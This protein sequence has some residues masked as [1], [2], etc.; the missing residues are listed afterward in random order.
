MDPRDVEKNNRIVREKDKQR[1]A[2]WAQE[3]KALAQDKKLRALPPA[4]EQV[5]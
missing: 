4:G 5:Q 3:K 1:Y 2:R